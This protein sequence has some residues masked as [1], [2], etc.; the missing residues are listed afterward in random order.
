[1]VFW[2]AILY[3]NISHFSHVSAASYNE[4]LLLRN[5]PTSPLRFFSK[6]V[7]P[8]TNSAFLP[9]RGTYYVVY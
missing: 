8:T 6:N 9:H 4:M 2:T 5:L 3:V 7:C 1:M